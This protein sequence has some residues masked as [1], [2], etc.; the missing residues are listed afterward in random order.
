MRSHLAFPKMLAAALLMLAAP[1]FAAQDWVAKSDEYTALRLH[2]DAK[3]SPEQAA[4]NGLDGYD[5]K[6]MDLTPGFYE[7]YRKELRKVLSEYEKALKK[8]EHPA[9]RQDLEILINDAKQTLEVMEVYDKHFIDYYNLPQSVFYS[10]QSLIN[11]QVDASRQ[12]AAL[13][14]LRKY[15]GMEKGFTPVFEHA[16]R[17]TARDLKNRK[18]LGPYVR[19]LE[20]DLENMP[21]FVAGVRDLFAN[22]DVEDW[23]P[24][25]DEFEKQVNDY[26][27]WL[28]DNLLPRARQTSQLPPEVYALNLKLFGTS[29][30]PQELISRATSGYMDI[31]VEMEAIAR[32]IA[33]ERGFKS[34]DY[35]D[36]IRE[37]K[38]E[39]FNSENIMPAYRERLKQLEAIVREHDLVTLPERDAII[40]LASE[41]ES[42]AQPAPHMQPP[43]MIGNTGE[44]GQFVLPLN[45]PNADSDAKMDDF[46]NDAIAWTLT[47]HEA[48][49]GHEMQFAKMVENGVSQARMLYA[50]NSANVEGWGLYA[51]AIMLPYLPLEGQLMSLQM[52]LMRAARAFLDPM[53]NLGMTDYDTVKNFLINEVVL[54]EPMAVQEADRYTFRAPGQAT[55]YYYGHMKLQELRAKTELA[56]GDKFNQ[57]EFH[58]FL[59]AQGILPPELMAKAVEEE[60]VK[61]RL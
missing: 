23:E 13:E 47:V 17:E 48:R 53:V 2:M 39:Q 31:R 59:L 29:M 60:F 55:A 4:R 40:R 6:I 34:S 1:A 26:V 11:P 18:L 7:R 52:R 61:P 30:D 33:E 35:R 49:P 43:R 27:A 25:V 3:F 32:R 36:V 19:E 54:S 5:D 51:E 42:A 28:R 56:L 50:F 41:A 44:Q 46:L 10:I 20:T 38:K 57:K 12:P 22:S 37:L 14:R 8:E 58:D 15:T 21:R 24:V 16:K 45:N 9:V